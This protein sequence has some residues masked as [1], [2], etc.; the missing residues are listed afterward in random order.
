LAAEPDT[1]IGTAVTDISERV[2]ILVREE[3]ELAKA[4]VSEKVNRLIRGTVIAVC[5]GFF[6]LMAVVFLLHGLSWLGAVELWDGVEIYWGFLIVAGMLLILG[7][8]AGW[9]ATKAFKAGSPPTPEMAIDEAK[10]IKET[11]T[12]D[13]P[14]PAPA[15]LAA[16]ADRGGPPAA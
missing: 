12:G 1:K 5:A 10:K 14:P 7:G 3:I 4:E 13:E 15:G 16:P 8:I 9:L 11:V 2:S 6:A